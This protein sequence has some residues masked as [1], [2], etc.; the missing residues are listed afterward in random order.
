MTKLVQGN[1][2]HHC[3]IRKKG[4]R[5]QIWGRR[6]WSSKYGATQYYGQWN[7]R[8]FESRACSTQKLNKS[9][10][11]EFVNWWIKLKPILIK[12]IF[13]LTYSKSMSTIHSARIRRRWSTNWATSSTSNFAKRIPGYNV[14]I[15]YPTGHKELYIVLVERSLNNTEE[16][17]KLNQGRFDVSSS[18]HWIIKKRSVHGAR[19][20]KSKEQTCYHQWFNA[21]KGCRKKTDE[22]GIH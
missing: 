13:K 18:S 17:R 3:L 4:T 10:K 22:A 5:R 2:H 11:D 7:F 6:K 16:V 14:P 8:I 20:G 1:L 12:E 19:H 21:W 15:V 9:K